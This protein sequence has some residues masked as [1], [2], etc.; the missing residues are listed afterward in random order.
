MFCVDMAPCWRCPCHVLAWGD[1][2]LQGGGQ[3][4]PG[5]WDFLRVNYRHVFGN[6]VRYIQQMIGVLAARNNLKV[7]DARKPVVIS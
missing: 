3:I 6:T 7:K 4:S 2:L 5:H 1:F